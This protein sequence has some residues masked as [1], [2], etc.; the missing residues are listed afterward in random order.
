MSLFASLAR[1]PALAASSFVFAFVAV[2]CGAGASPIAGEP[3]KSGEQKPVNAASAKPAAAA[4]LRLR[5]YTVNDPMMGCDAFTL[6]V[7]EGWKVEGG[8][9]WQM[10][11]ANLAT[12]QMRIFDPQSA[13]ALEV[14]PT[15]PYTWDSNGIPF[16]PPGSNYM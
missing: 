8:V 4:P 12:G 6:L 10:E 13:A 9:A 16:F 2:S 11:Y 7:P 15:I 1:P 14:L 5:K 3:S